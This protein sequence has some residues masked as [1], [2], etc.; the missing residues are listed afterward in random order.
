MYSTKNIENIL[1]AASL[2]D[3]TQNQYTYYE[4]IDEIKEVLFSG[5]FNQAIEAYNKGVIIYRGAKDLAK[6]EAL[7]VV[8]GIRRSQDTSNLY[9]KLIS[10][11][12]PSWRGMPKRNRS[13]IAVT[14]IA[15]A[16]IYA[17]GA[18]PFAVFPVDNTELVVCK[19]NDAWHS[20][21]FLRQKF[22]ID[23]ISNFNYEFKRFMTDILDISLEEAENIFLGGNNTIIQAFNEIDEYAKDITDPDT[24]LKNYDKPYKRLFKTIIGNIQ[25]G[26][27]LLTLLNIILSAKNNGFEVATISEIPNNREVWFSTNSLSIRVDI[28]EQIFQ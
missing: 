13:I 9:N 3:K 10:D 4:G 17:K 24:F 2:N 20:F 26:K 5:K 25:Q 15:V 6:Y 19:T 22:G 12:L 16:N 21:T 7:Y 27:S 1:I 11:I 18:L 28:A 14:N 23:A 8:P